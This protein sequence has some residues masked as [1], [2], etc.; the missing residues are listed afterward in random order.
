MPSVGVAG[1]AGKVD[2]IGTIAALLKPHPELLLVLFFN[3]A[4]RFGTQTWS[5]VFINDA[6]IV[7][8]VDRFGFD[9]A[10][11]K[12]IHLIGTGSSTLSKKPVNHFQSFIETS[13]SSN[14]DDDPLHLNLAA[15][16]DVRGIRGK[17]AVDAAVPIDVATTAPLGGDADL[18]GTS[19]VGAGL[20][21]PVAVGAS[22]NTVCFTKFYRTYQA[23]KHPFHQRLQRSVVHAAHADTGTTDRARE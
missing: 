18:V 7:G 19:R 21:R 15:P 14:T 8:I 2:I 23:R 22:V 11:T 5:N 13:P 6:L 4:H 10:L 16:S 20:G 3:L 1:V 12:E 9:D 17:L